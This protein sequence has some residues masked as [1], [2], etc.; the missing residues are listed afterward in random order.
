MNSSS[1]TDAIAAAQAELVVHL[2]DTP[3]LVEQAYRLRHQVYCLERGYE[4]GVNDLETDAYDKHARHVVLSLRGC[5]TVIGTVRMILPQARQPTR[6]FP[7]QA[8]CDRATLSAVPLRSAV[9]VSRFAVSK[10]RRNISPAAASLSR[11]ALVRGLVQL[12]QQA[13]V[14]HWC[15]VMERTLLRLLRSSGIH[16]EAVGPLVEY[17]GLRQPAFCELAGMLDRMRA[18]Q[19]AIW[20][21]VTNEGQFVTSRS[22]ALQAA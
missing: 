20:N 21:F 17:H 7:M 22:H 13:G 3:A 10:E 12:S 1:L 11:L 14:T 8:V 6:S 5:G 18:E 15:A 2:A 4:P 9:E 16:F 19:P